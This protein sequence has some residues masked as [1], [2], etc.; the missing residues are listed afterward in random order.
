MIHDATQT[1]PEDWRARLDA[2]VA[3]RMHAPFTWGANDC[4]MFAADAAL[5]VSGFDFA[6]PF[7]GIYDT[8]E[9]AR[10]VLDSVG[11]IEGAAS[12]GA[13]GI[14]PLFATTGDIGLIG[15]GLAVCIGTMWLAPA[16]RGLAA[17]T[18]DIAEKAWRV[19]RA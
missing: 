18:L 2:L 19:R 6:K 16:R 10:E 13:D 15:D 1:V 11:G 4:C 7:R 5:A 8:E 12:L 9:Q 14:E 17:F 3:E